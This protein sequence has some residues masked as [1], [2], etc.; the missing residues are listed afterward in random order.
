MWANMD[1]QCQ[2][3]QNS[4]G[5]CRDKWPPNTNYIY[6]SLWCDAEDVFTNTTAPE[7]ILPP[8]RWRGERQKS[9]KR[10]KRNRL[11]LIRPDSRHSARE[12]V[13][14]SR[15]KCPTHEPN[16]GRA[17]RSEVRLSSQNS[18]I[19]SLYIGLITAFCSI[20]PKVLFQLLSHCCMWS[21][22]LPK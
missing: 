1:T 18:T 9:G 11:F 3:G 19:V 2:T 16:L 17:G 15:E 13:F 7:S 21:S 22:Y 5:L 10:R 6:L 20:M 14:A 12:F 8:R 4:R